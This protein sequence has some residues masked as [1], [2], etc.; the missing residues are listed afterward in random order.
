MIAISDIILLTVSSAVLAVA[1]VRSNGDSSATQDNMLQTP[2][3]SVSQNSVQSA[4]QT[5]NTS[6]ASSGNA[7]NTDVATT[8]ITAPT[9]TPIL[10][11]I[12][13]DTDTDTATLQYS[14]YTVQSGDSLSKIARNFGTSVS[15]LQSINNLSNTRI[16]V[17]QELRYQTP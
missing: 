11:E 16:L 10:V 14:T 8:Q 3:S 6:E 4:T 15:E 5:D 12:D 1:L 2:S 13:T 7:E 17:G 9:V